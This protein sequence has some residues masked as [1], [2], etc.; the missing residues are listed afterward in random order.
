MVLAGFAAAVPRAAG[1]FTSRVSLVEVYATVT[2]TR[3]RLVK[4]L[5][6]EDFTVAEDGAPQTIQAFAYGE[7]PLTVAVGLDRSFSMSDQA[8]AAAVTATRVFS[9]RLEPEDQLMILG[10]GSETEVLAPL[11]TDRAVARRSLERIARWGTTPLYDAVIRSIDAVQPA[12]G[13]RALI[14]LSDGDDR[15][16]QA[17]ASD[18]VAYARQHDVLVYP[19]SIGNSRV[20]VWA[21]VATVSGGRSYN[22]KDPKTLAATMGEIADELRHQYLIGYVPPFEGASGWRSIRVRVNRPD[23]RVRARDGYRATDR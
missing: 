12:P 16:S 15:Y 14:L 17:T 7:F 19:V 8:L 2:D 23:V 10:I 18:V 1:Q 13:R 4:G 22:V 11:S 20:P 6:A 5:R 9:E 3:G 21:E